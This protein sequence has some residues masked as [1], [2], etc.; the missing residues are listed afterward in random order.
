MI[1]GVF[2]ILSKFANLALLKFNT[3]MEDRLAQNLSILKIKSAIRVQNQ[4]CDE[5]VIATVNKDL[6]EVEKLTAQIDNINQFIISVV[7][8]MSGIDQESVL[9]RLDGWL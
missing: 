6:K 4:T 1:L 9:Q 8:K 2:G 7:S 5:L 3:G